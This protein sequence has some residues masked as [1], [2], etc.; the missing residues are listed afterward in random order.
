MDSSM[1]HGNSY[2]T[3]KLLSMV[4]SE[5][6]LRDE[7]DSKNANI[8]IKNMFNIRKLLKDFLKDMFSFLIFKIDER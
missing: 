6:K 1:P 2:F 8:I 4:I 5:D 7:G 3:R